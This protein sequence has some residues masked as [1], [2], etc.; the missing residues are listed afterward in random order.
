LKTIDVYHHENA[1]L[2]Q[3]SN[4]EGVYIVDITNGVGYSQNITLV[5]NQQNV[6]FL[7][8]GMPLISST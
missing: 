4:E 2:Y 1:S 3:I 5:V 6:F 7:M 8:P